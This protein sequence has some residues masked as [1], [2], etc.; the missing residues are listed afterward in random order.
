MIQP[1][2]IETKSRWRRRIYKL[3]CLVFTYT[4]I[5]WFVSVGF[6]F[7]LLPP[8]QYKS[9]Y[10]VPY[11]GHLMTHICLGS[12]CLSYSQ[13]TILLRKPRSLFQ[14]LARWKNAVYLCESAETTYRFPSEFSTFTTIM[15]AP[16]DR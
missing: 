3:F 1:P 10:L 6:C 5:L 11:L 4:V 14:K 8:A 15:E 2:T 16:I 9:P 12:C 13:I 7:L